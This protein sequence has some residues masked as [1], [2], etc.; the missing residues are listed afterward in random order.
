VIVSTD[1]QQIADVAGSLGAEVPFLRPSELASDDSPSIDLVIHAINWLKQA[2]EYSPH[3]VVL[4]QPT[5]PL[6]TTK[7]IVAALSVFQDKA[8][9]NDT[10]MSVKPAEIH[11][12]YFFTIDDSGCME[13]LI[14]GGRKVR[15]QD[16]PQVFRPNGAIY[17]GGAEYLLS[18]KRFEGDR[19]LAYIMPEER[20]L[21]VDEP[22][23]LQMAEFSL[24]ARSPR[25]IPDRR[26]SP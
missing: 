25:S 11:P 8:G 20:S 5:S 23:H 21:D 26:R 2:E 7:D 18:S 22:W 24:Q 1:R 10:L 13:E 3:I 17:I 19:T 12:N 15:R 6:R 4:L 9:D 16:M 14:K